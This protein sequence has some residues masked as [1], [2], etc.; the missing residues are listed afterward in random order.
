[1]TPRLGTDGTRMV[2]PVRGIV[3]GFLSE[4]QQA[5][6][7]YVT[8]LVVAALATTVALVAAGFVLEAPFTV[9]ALAIAAAWQNGSTSA[10]PSTRAA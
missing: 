9:L 4:P 5:T 7:L 6:V 3:Q 8:T 10:S 2:Y 1:M